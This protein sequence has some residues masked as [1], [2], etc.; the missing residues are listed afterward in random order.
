V[1]VSNGRQ[2]IMGAPNQY[3]LHGDGIAV[4]YYPGGDGPI[5][6]GRGRLVLSYQ[7]AFQSRGFDTDDVRVVEVDDLGSIVSVTLVLT[8]DVGYTSFS[9]LVPEVLLP[10]Q[11]E[12]SVYVHTRGITTV[13]R[14]FA[15]LIGHPQEET[16]R[17]TE[18][19]G[20]ASVG[21]MAL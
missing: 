8:V 11:P 17:V 1:I 4:T 14:A 19:Y 9:L 13:H 20:T 16:Y 6:Q 3:H 5:I 12:P 21:P 10:D 18:L 7:D 2:S 15:G